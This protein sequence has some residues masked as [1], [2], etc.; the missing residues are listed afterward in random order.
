MNNS[1]YNNFDSRLQEERQHWPTCF[2]TLHVFCSSSSPL[3]SALHLL[4]PLPC[5]APCLLPNSRLW[6][7][8]KVAASTAIV[9]KDPKREGMEVGDKLQT[10]HSLPLGRSLSI[11]MW[12]QKRL[13]TPGRKG[14]SAFGWICC[15]R[16]TRTAHTAF[17]WNVGT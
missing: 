10:L 11:L 15:E 12:L 9:K 1:V 7:G 16:Y 14:Q 4:T 8:R 6:A 17:D 5:D 13:G 3:D 2:Q